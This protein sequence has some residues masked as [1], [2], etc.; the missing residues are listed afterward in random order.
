MSIIRT[1]REMGLGLD[2]F[3]IT[4]DDFPA[5]WSDDPYEETD[6]DRLMDKKLY[7]N[8]EVTLDTHKGWLQRGRFL[9][10]SVASS[11]TGFKDNVAY[12]HIDQTTDSSTYRDEL[13]E[14]AQNA[15][16]NFVEDVDLNGINSE[17]DLDEKFEAMLK[18][19]SSALKKS[20][21]QFKDCVQFEPAFIPS[22]P[23]IGFDRSK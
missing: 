15:I 9:F 22:N 17:S 23:G 1:V 10:S 4:G 2:H 11:P 8:T 14:V 20:H 12:F 18:N 13:Q 3:L 7:F 5:S 21:N 16:E 19:L 6:R